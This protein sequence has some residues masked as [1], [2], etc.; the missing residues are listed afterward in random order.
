M[1]Q[2]SF[3]RCLAQDRRRA[4]SRAGKAMAPAGRSISFT[5][6]DIDSRRAATT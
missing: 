4:K 5:A 6:C 1:I 3:D 2:L